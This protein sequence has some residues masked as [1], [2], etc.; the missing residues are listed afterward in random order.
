M[1]YKNFKKK[2]NKISIDGTSNFIEALYWIKA[3]W[4]IRK[5]RKQY[6]IPKS[7]PILPIM[8]VHYDFKIMDEKYNQEE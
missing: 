4:I 7:V 8:I 6:K 3:K 5:I 1:K 2:E